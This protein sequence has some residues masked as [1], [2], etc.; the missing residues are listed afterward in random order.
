MRSIFVG[1]LFLAACAALG[2][3]QGAGSAALEDMKA[4]V[5]YYQGCESLKPSMEGEQVHPD[6]ALQSGKI[7]RA[8]LIERRT[9]N[10]VADPDF[11]GQPKDAWLLI[12]QPAQMEKGGSAGPG[13]CAVTAADYVRQVVS[14]LTEGRL[15][16][17]SVYARTDEGGALSLAA[18]CGGTRQ[19]A[20]ARALGGAYS[21]V[22]LSFVAGAAVATLTIRGASEKKVVV[23]AVQLEEGKSWPASFLPDTG[24]MRGCDWVDIPPR[25]FNPTKGSVAFWVKP[26]WLGE[27]GMGGLGFFAAF[28]DPNLGWAAQRSMLSVG[29]YTNPQKKG[30]ENGLNINLKDK[31]GNAMGYTVEFDERFQPKPGEWLHVVVTWDLPT[32]ADSVSRCFVNGR[33]AAEKR[34]RCESF[35]PAA[36]VYMGYVSGAY[37]D[38]LMD[39]FAL[40]NRPLTDAEAADLFGATV[41]LK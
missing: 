41:P 40:F 24:K 32:G 29:A 34:F 19:E 14:G 35:E 15:Y 9:V 8:F 37:A 5:T 6:P 39:E 28:K 25:A 1:R 30:W 3:G 10:L 2:L 33:P 26:Q 22:H 20:P 11:A 21:R 16:C 18:K 27:T 17:F 13:C 23:D 31:A 38:A 12:G 7:G 4:A 36:S